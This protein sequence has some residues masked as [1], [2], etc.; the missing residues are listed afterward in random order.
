[1]TYAVLFLSFPASSDGPIYLKTF[2]IFWTFA[3]LIAIVVCVLALAKEGRRSGAF[4][5][6]HFDASAS[7]WTPGWSWFVGLLQAAYVTSSTGMVVSMCEEVDKPEIQVPR[8]MSLFF[9][10]AYMIIPSLMS[11]EYRVYTV[12]V[13]FVFGSAFLIPLMFVLPDLAYLNT[14]MS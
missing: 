10:R 3:G 2:A 7:G 13:N 1:L 5:F 11:G 14:R 8:A 12:I 9:I 4:A 6:G